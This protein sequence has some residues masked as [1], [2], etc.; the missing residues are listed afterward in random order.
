[1]ITFNFIDSKNIHS[2]IPFLQLLH[3]NISEETLKERLSAMVKQNY[4]CIG[5]YDDKEL[6]GICGI[7]TLIKYYVGKHIELDNVIVL[8]KYQS[9]GI[10]TKLMNYIDNYSK[11]I[12]CVGNELNCYVHNEEG[13]K[14]WEKEGYKKIGYHFQKK[15]LT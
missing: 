8:P 5:I 12:G 4:Q 10:G 13:N 7:W 15:F 2:I 9:S 1:M 6:I 11:E 3:S 14:F